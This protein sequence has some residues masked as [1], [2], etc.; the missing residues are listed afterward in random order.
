[1]PHV[2]HA[3]RLFD[4]KIWRKKKDATT[5]SNSA[6]VLDL[7]IIIIFNLNLFNII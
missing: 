7:I 3:R 6:S 4:V 2:R 5:A 1:M